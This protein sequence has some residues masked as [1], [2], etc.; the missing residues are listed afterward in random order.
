MVTDTDDM[1]N[2]RENP[3]NF[4]AYHRSAVRVGA[5]FLIAASQVAGAQQRSP[6][7]EIDADVLSAIL[8]AALSD[9]GRVDLRVDPR[10]LI[11]DAA[12]LYTVR[13]EVLASVSASIVQGRADIIRAAG[14]RIV[15]TTVVNQSRE[16]P[17]ALVISQRDSLGHVNDK[18]VVGCPE[19]PFAV[20]AVGP[21]RPGSAVVPEDQVY[22]R[23]TETAARRYWAAR[24]I[25]TTLG[26]G[27]SSV[28]AADYVLAERS[29]K[30]V[31][32]K[33]VGLMYSE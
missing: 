12:Y 13:P 4:F 3:K 5:F 32:I 16:C 21:P 1:N 24:V 11:A 6:G 19:E 10:P 25:R 28:Y 26:H 23:A 8:K 31:V 33:I 17:G 15:D 27:R 9:A 30:W 20:V 7:A 2:L 29:G 18:H 14:L 22:D